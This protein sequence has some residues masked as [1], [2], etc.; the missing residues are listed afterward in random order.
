[1]VNKDIF[2]QHVLNKKYVIV[3]D[4]QVILEVLALYK[5]NKLDVLVVKDW[6][7]KLKIV[8]EE[9]VCLNLF[10]RNVNKKVIF[11]KIV[12][13]NKLKQKRNQEENL[14]KSN[15]K[16]HKNHLKIKKW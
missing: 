1:M 16:K 8:Q 10:V 4:N 6:D 5:Y 13:I 15:N 2:H 14:L 9:I 12:K 11:G 3:V 7:I